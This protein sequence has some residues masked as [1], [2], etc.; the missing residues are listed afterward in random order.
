[1]N[2]QRLIEEPQLNRDLE[3]LAAQLRQPEHAVSDIV[4]AAGHQYVD[5]VMEGGGLLGLALV[6]YSWALEQMGLRFLGIGGTS[7]GA[8][9]A[10][11][12]AGLDEPEHAKS[13][14][15]LRE[16][17]RKDFYDFV[18]G[19][20]DVR[21]LIDLGLD[22]RPLG[23]FK[24]MRLIGRFIAVRHRLERTYGLNPGNHFLYWLGELLRSAGVATNADL[25][26]RLARRPHGFAR[27]GNPP[28]ADGD[29]D[30]P[31]AR[32]VIVAADIW[33][34]T[35]VELPAMAALYWADTDQ[36]DPALFARASMSLPF[37]FEPLRIKPLPDGAGWQRWNA[38][39]GLYP[40]QSSNRAPPDRALLVDGGLLSNFPINAFHIPDRVPRLP[41]FGVKLEYDKR[42]D[43][44]R[45]YSGNSGLSGLAGY[46]GM[47]FNSARHQ[48]DYEFIR[49]NPDYKHLVQYIPCVRE[50]PD[51]R[52]EPIDWLDFNLPDED[53]ELLFRQGAEK[54]IEFV[55]AF[56]SPVDAKGRSTD[57]PGPD[58]FSS[59]WSFYKELRRRLA[60][61]VEP[62]SEGEL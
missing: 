51:G 42:V 48:L 32:L 36:V 26:A 62:T 58:G 18:D 59:K 22:G 50:Y 3:A 56:S 2:I 49:R 29:P 54:A 7:A 19:G 10:L 25:A 52:T 24:L 60:Q 61:V 53:K 38:M 21:D 6:G 12:L 47:L 46:T 45:P 5:L 8:I 11:L 43:T 30:A 27:R 55:R 35:R 23:T 37:F 39:A 1:M 16:L 28:F 20:R 13:S 44:S 17:D 4:D 34:E 15:L 40:E 9:N 31:Q 33:S 41:T 57:E 14:Q